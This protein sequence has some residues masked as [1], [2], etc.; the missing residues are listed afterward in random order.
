MAIPHSPKLHI[1]SNEMNNRKV[2]QVLSVVT[3]DSSAGYSHPGVCD[4][5]GNEYIGNC[6]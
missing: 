5:Y 1:F 3:I 6:I 4:V 2:L